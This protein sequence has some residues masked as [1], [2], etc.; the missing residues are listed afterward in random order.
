MFRNF[1]KKIMKFQN[2]WDIGELHHYLNDLLK[3][4]LINIIYKFI[5]LLKDRKTSFP[6]CNDYWKQIY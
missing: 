1:F 5:I 3:Y 2:H 4:F 6:T